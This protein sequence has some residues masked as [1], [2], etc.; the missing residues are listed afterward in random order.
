MFTVTVVFLLVVST[1]SNSISAIVAYFFLSH[2]RKWNR[3]IIDIA[4]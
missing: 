1:V 4:D 2:L 3:P